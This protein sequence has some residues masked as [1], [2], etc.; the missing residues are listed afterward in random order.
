MS[1]S[2]RCGARAG[3]SLEGSVIP[4]LPLCWKGAHAVPVMVAEG[5]CV[6]QSSPQITAA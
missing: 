5:A 3:A 2:V 1:F 4:S 6:T